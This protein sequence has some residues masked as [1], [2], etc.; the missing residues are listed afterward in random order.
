MRLSE[1]FSETKTASVDV[2][3]GKSFNITYKPQMITPEALARFGALQNVSPDSVN[4]GIEQLALV[5]GIADALI[6][7]AHALGRARHQRR[8]QDR[9]I[10][11][12]QHFLQFGARRERLAG[13]GQHEAAAH[14]HPAGLHVGGLDA[15]GAP[16]ARAHELQ[17]AAEGLGGGEPGKQGIFR[18]DGKDS[19]PLGKVRMNPDS[20]VYMETPGGGGFGSPRD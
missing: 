7:K 3:E 10:G 15:G 2:G 11:G 4:V 8:A 1:I 19:Y 17:R 16:A 12:A 20:V 5:T 9:V 13:A 6:A 14:L 18:I